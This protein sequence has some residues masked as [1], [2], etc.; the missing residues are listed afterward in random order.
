MEIER[1][2]LLERV[3]GVLREHRGPEACITM[4]QLYHA[5]TDDLVIPQ[6]RYDQTRIVRSVVEQLRREGCPIALKAGI[7][8]GYFWARSEA[9][10]DT[11]VRWFH[12]RA[13]SSLQQEA[14]L[15]RVPFGELLRQYHLEL[16]D[17]E[18]E[19]Q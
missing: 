16:E 10:L 2:E 18:T 17:T 7:G 15:K 4:T 19:T 9:E 12:R 5:V 11:T 3:R 1:E 14:A 8:G 13:M 6:R